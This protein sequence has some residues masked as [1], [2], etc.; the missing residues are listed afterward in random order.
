M[1]G[2]DERFQEVALISKKARFRDIKN[3]TGERTL[4]QSL[5]MARPFSDAPSSSI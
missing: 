2:F 3:P 1:G 5:K 4:Q